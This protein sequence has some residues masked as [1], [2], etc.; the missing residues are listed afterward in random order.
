MQTSW[1]ELSY[2]QKMKTL[3]ILIKTQVTA[4]LQ[5]VIKGFDKSLFLQLAPPF[6]PINLLRFDGNKKGDTVSLEL[7]MLLFKQQWTSLITHD[8]ESQ[9]HFSFTDEGMRLP[10]FLKK[11]KH[12]HHL[13]T[14]AHGTLITDEIYFSSGAIITDVLLYPI[15]FIQFLYRKPIYKRIFR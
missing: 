4:R 3:K 10:F 8:E 1:R 11:W 15:L 12:I 2:Y 13:E 5:K 6:P 9:K 14:N 7:N